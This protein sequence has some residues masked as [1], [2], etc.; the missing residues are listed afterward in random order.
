MAFGKADSTLIQADRATYGVDPML[1]G[2]AAVGQLTQN[3]LKAQGDKNK[4]NREN[5]AKFDAAYIKGLDDNTGFAHSKVQDQVTAYL[6][7]QSQAYAD[8]EGNPTAQAEI[9][10]K[11]NSHVNAIMRMEGLIKGHREFHNGEETFALNSD[12]TDLHFQREL[13][14]GNY[15][16]KEDEN[17]VVKYGILNPDGY[18]EESEGNITWFDENNLPLGSDF[19]DQG[20]EAIL[21]VFSTEVNG[22]TDGWE[23][24]PPT[25]EQD[26]KDKFKGMNLSFFDLKTLLGQDP[27]GDG[28]EGNDFY[29]KFTRGELSDEY[30]N[31][32]TGDFKKTLDKNDPDALKAWLN[33]TNPNGTRDYNDTGGRK[34]VITDLLAKYMGEITTAGYEIKQKDVMQKQNRYFNLPGEGGMFMGKGGKAPTAHAVKAKRLEV[35]KD[36]KFN[37]V[38]GDDYNENTTD[39]N[40]LVTDDGGPLLENLLATY[41][42]EVKNKLLDFDVDN[43]IL[44]VKVEG[45]ETKEFNFNKGT[46][47]DQVAMLKKLQDEIATFNPIEADLKTL[48]TDANEWKMTIRDNLPFTVKK[49][50]EEKF[51]SLNAEEW[52]KVETAV[53]EH[54]DWEWDEENELFK[55][56]DGTQMDYVQ[57]MAIK[58]N[59]TDNVNT[60]DN[61]GGGDT[62]GDGVLLNQGDQVRA[63]NTEI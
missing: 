56:A 19:H 14:A 5:K 13:R 46:K 1:Q 28:I 45:G 47:E 27:G 48:G 34:K 41:S 51:N 21:N 37:T 63:T 17:G 57:L 10:R 53:G 15:S 25:F 16:V 62:G 43:G 38:L 52:A 8:M 59:Q 61:T 6:K 35:Y 3:M 22:R 42:R 2:A 11:S 40:R 60:E 12:E 29:G 23:G 30:Y 33:N 54:G 18:G 24:A 32:G 39:F 31:V 50:T 4:R 49:A 36:Q 7:S 20:G 44:K 58:L 26:Y 55:F 9:L